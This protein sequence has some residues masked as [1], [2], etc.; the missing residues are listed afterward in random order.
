MICSPTSLQLWRSKCLILLLSCNLCKQE[1]YRE[2]IANYI[3]SIFYKYILID[4]HN[5][6]RVS[7]YQCMEILIQNH[8]SSWLNWFFAYLAKDC[9]E[10]REKDSWMMWLQEHISLPSVEIH[11]SILQFSQ[12]TSDSLQYDS[13]IH[14]PLNIWIGVCFLFLFT[15]VS[16]SPDN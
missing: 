13:L 14:Y 1:K 12:I 10:Q 3:E 11:N 15:I 2:N 6:V 16:S 5:E 7:L 9:E 4:S 8:S